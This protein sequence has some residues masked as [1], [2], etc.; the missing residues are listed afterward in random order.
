MFK[1]V[2]LALRCQEQNTNICAAQQSVRNQKFGVAGVDSF[3]AEIIYRT[4][5]YLRIG[6]SVTTVGFDDHTAQQV[7]RRN[8]LHHFDHGDAGLVAAHYYLRPPPKGRA[9]FV[10]RQLF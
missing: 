9:K 2:F 1:G 4:L 7:R 8:G 6:I 10:V 3:V 5:S